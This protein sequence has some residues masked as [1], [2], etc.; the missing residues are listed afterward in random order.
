[1]PEAHDGVEAEDKGARVA[2]FN[3]LVGH[4]VSQSVVERPMGDETAQ[5]HESRTAALPAE[6]ARCSG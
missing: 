6:N 4:A 3:L 1:M 2:A 5:N